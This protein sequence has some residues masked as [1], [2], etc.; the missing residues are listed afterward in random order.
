MDATVIDND[1]ISNPSVPG[2]AIRSTPQKP[3]ARAV[4]VRGPTRLCKKQKAVEALDEM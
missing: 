4:E 3:A 2:L 1:A